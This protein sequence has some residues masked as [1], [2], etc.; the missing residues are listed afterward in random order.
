M[1]GPPLIFVALARIV[2]GL[3]SS[4]VSG[5][6]NAAVFT[7]DFGLALFNLIAPNRSPHKVV[8]DG[9][10][11]AGGIWPRYVAPGDGDSRCSCPALNA[12]AN[13]GT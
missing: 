1:S 13:H 2:V 12:M 8:P 10:V 5:L 6:T 3:Y 4:V 7:W 11:G 9:F